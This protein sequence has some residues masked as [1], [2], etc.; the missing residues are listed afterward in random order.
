M[1]PRCR[2]QACSARLGAYTTT[3]LVND[4]PGRAIV[5]HPPAFDDQFRARFREL[6]AWRRDVRRFQT[7]PP[8][9][10]IISELLD[11]A[12]LAPSVGNSQPWR[13]VLVEDP[14]RRARVVE[15]F[16]RCN[17]AALAMYSGERASLY[18]RL[19]LAGLQ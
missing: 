1:S 3:D 16:R 9:P 11:L 10:G 18:A 4:Q 19:K 5:V 14:A 12:R 17:D 8:D 2:S 15:D 7:R 6:L 13:F